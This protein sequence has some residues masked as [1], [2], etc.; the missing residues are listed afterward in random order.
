MRQAIDTD[1]K[2]LSRIIGYA[3]DTWV[4]CEGKVASWAVF[5]EHERTAKE[6]RLV[7]SIDVVLDDE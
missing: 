1:P 3:A 5:N 6:D 7:L 4:R 2:R